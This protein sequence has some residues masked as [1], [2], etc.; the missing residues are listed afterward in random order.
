M[1]EARCACCGVCVWSEPVAVV[2]R[3]TGEPVTVFL[4]KRCLAASPRRTWRLRWT[5]VAEAALN[6][7]GHRK[8]GAGRCATAH[9]WDFSID[10][11]ASITTTEEDN[12][13]HD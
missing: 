11:S 10:A 7:G 8:R 2:D 1:A 12:D 4:C 3:L 6:H 5:P 9:G 13:G